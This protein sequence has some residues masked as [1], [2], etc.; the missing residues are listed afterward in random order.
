MQGSRL[1]ER[2][3]DGADAGPTTRVAAREDAG[4]HR[5][6][7]AVG[8]RIDAR[9]RVIQRALAPTFGLGERTRLLSRHDVAGVEHEA[10]PRVDRRRRGIEGWRI[11]AEILSDHAPCGGGDEEEGEEAVQGGSD[12]ID[13]FT[14]P[15]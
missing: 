12:A 2:T 15:R 4:A 11:A 9:R 5:R 6:P 10:A 7:N 14:A 1:R 8:V 3:N 13:A